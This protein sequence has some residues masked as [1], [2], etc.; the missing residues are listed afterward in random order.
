MPVGKNKIFIRLM[1]N[2]VGADALSP[3][4]IYAKGRK[5]YNLKKEKKWT[6]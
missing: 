5:I 4:A 2:V 1:S 6:I 3:P